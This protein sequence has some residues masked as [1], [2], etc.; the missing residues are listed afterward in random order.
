MS[1]LQPAYLM[2]IKG[3]FFLKVSAIFLPFL[4]LFE[5]ILLM[6][7]EHGEPFRHGGSTGVAQPGVFLDVAKLH[8][9][10]LQAPDKAYPGNVRL[11]IAALPV[12]LS[13][14]LDQPQFFIV[15]QGAGWQAGFGG[16]FSDGHIFTSLY[17]FIFGSYLFH[18]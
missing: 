6:Q 9:G 18:L 14:Y 15:A 11:R 4:L 13:V 17:S 12:W 3:D 5:D 7:D 2:L 10:F 1:Y 16:N 8:A